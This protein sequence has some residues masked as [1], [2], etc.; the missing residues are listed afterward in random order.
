MKSGNADEIVYYGK[1]T[2]DVLVGD[3]DGDGEDTFAV[4]R[5]NM[6]YIKNSVSNGVA[7]QVTAYGRSDDEVYVG[8]W[9]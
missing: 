8:S 2:D 9:Q 3:W 6:Y 7:D 5:G 4:R 1:S